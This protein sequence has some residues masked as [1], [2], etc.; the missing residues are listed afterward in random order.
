MFFQPNRK[1]C[2]LVFEINTLIFA[3]ACSTSDRWCRSRRMFINRKTLTRQIIERLPGS[4][5]RSLNGTFVEESVRMIG[6]SAKCVTDNGDG[7]CERN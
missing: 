5:S 7:A 2:V 1:K 3:R 4:L 6:V